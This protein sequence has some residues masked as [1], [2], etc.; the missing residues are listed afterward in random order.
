MDKAEYE[1]SRREL[2]NR[3]KKVRKEYTNRAEGKRFSLD[4]IQDYDAWEKA[5]PKILF[6]LKENRA[7]RYDWE[8]CQA[9]NSKANIFSLNLIRWRQLLIDSYHK[10][11]GEP[12][13][14]RHELPASVTDVA[15]VEVKK[16][17]EG[18]GSSSDSDIK[19]YAIKDRDFIR[20]QI[21]LINPDIIF[22]C[23]TGELYD[24]IIYNDEQW[25]LLINDS[26]CNCYKH[27][28]RLVIDFFHPSTRS[29]QKEKELFDT[30]HRMILNGKVFEKF[31]WETKS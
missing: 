31:S 20:E 2:F 24:E 21:K 23:Y 5:S 22:C 28:N 6:L 27:G 1:K 17:N 29:K 25:D 30:L 9:I 3:W 14:L 26:R 13:F 12:A 18:K 11:P 10:K 8:P 7:P 19:F 4:G 15:N 16:L